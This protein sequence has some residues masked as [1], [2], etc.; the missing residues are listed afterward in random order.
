MT[1]SSPKPTRRLC[2][3]E[4]MTVANPISPLGWCLERSRHF[5]PGWSGSGQDSLVGKA[6][7]QD[8][9][10]APGLHSTELCSKL[11]V[12]LGTEGDDRGRDL[13]SGILAL[14]FGL[15]TLNKL[16][17]QSLSSLNCRMG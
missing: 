2:S 1:H 9:W 3:L 7:Q 16:A 15:E 17:C 13:A 5:S 12:F 4:E 6:G 10:L 11:E 14:S 8:S